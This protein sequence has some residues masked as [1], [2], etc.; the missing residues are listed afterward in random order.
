MTKI[1]LDN[2]KQPSQKEADKLL[3]YYQNGQ[4]HEAEELALSFTQEF[5]EYPLSWKILGAIFR[6]TDRLL[7]AL[8][9][10]KNAVLLAPKDFLAQNNLGIALKDSGA[11]DEAERCYRK[12]ITLRSTSADTHNNLGVVLKQLG[13]FD[14]AEESYGQAIAIE[15]MHLDALMNRWQLLFEKGELEAALKDSDICNNSISRPRSLATLYAL[16]RIDE[17]Y[18]RFK[19]QPEED[20]TNLDIA[21]FSAFIS[22]ITEKDTLH[23]FCNNPFDYIYS[24]NISSHQEDP[25]KF[26]SDTVE[27]LS[28]SEMIWEPRQ[29]TTRKGFQTPVN[30]NLLAQSSPKI[31]YLK[32]IIC[33]ELD[34]Y[35]KKFHKESCS[36]IQNWPQKMNLFGWQVILGKE[37]YQMPHIHSNGWLSGV[38]YLKVVPSLGRNEGAIEFSL[39]GIH[40]SDESSP[41]IIFQ[42]KLGDIVLFPSSLYHRTI[43]FT[44]DASRIIISF[45]LRPS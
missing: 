31:A 43:P 19:V 16:R 38:I 25:V 6:Q 13:R 27:E 7:E 12:A 11:L 22:H 18:Y 10:H 4:Y 23:N 34:A 45:D 1:I 42:P 17:I 29:K 36:Y 26:I 39:N 32:S 40:Y 35:Y 28:G 2:S 44:S 37:G 3:K 33:N 5:P 21:A 20:K 15:P 14:E 30:N 41:T 8:N 24:S 9:A